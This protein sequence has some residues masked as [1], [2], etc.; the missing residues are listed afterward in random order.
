MIVKFSSAFRAFA[1][2]FRIAYARLRGFRVLATILEQTKRLN[3]C[4]ACEELT[5]ERQCRICT[6]FVDV[7]TMLTTEGCP[8][9]KWLRIWEKRNTI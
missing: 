5:E 7:K 9:H 2:S 3:E 6:C 8:K 1:A 4:H